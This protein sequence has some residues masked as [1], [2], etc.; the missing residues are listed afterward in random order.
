[1]WHHFRKAD[2]CTVQTKDD[3]GTR[4]YSVGRGQMGKRQN[5]KQAAVGV[6][7]ILVSK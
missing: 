3:P 2:F 1:M 6:Y 4:R 7:Y 5:A